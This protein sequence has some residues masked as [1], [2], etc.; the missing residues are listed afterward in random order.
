MFGIYLG[1]LGQIDKVYYL[2]IVEIQVRLYL[3]FLST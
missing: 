2:L 1:V 3:N